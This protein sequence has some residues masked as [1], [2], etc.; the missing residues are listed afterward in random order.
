MLVRRTRTGGRRTRLA[1]LSAALA[2]TLLAGPAAAQQPAADA[3]LD[4]LIR[5]AM[6]YAYPYNEFMTMRQAALHDQD[7]PTATTLNHFRHARQLATP[8][9]RWANGPINDALYST[10]W[11]DVGRSPIVLSLPDTAGR[12]YVIALVGANLDTFAYVGRRI[13]GTAARRVAIVGPE[14][15]GTVP[16]VEQVIRAPTRD[17]YLNMRVLVDGPGDLPTAQALQ[18][19]FRTVPA[20]A[21]AGADEPG[22]VP[23]RGDWSRFVAVANESL[24]RNPPPPREAPLLARFR[25]VGICGSACSWTALPADVQAR[26]QRLAPEIEQT[27]KSRLDADRSTPDPRRQN[28]WVPY[29]LPASFGTNYLMRAAS[30]AMSGGILGVEAAEASYF[31]ASVD[32]QNA[33]LGQGAAYRLHLPQGRLPADAF[34]SISL[35]EFVP[36]GQYLVENPINRYAIGDRTRGLQFNSDGSLDIWIQPGDP[37]PAR[38]ANW[39]PSPAHNRFYLMARLYQP[40]P[41]ALDP[42][43]VLAPLEK[44]DH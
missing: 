20:D 13:S 7:G 16:G 33:A 18:D 42:S 22:V 14:W 32:G 24:A 26:W 5:E 8:K 30:A 35:Y 1:V 23:A 44:L 4:T 36:G 2:A 10:N 19:A 12:Y 11:L 39:L 37:G 6:L 29:R 34:W 28:G 15:R 31:A 25:Q 21:T 17:V 40:W 38:R 9:D 43:W 27:L 3:G 41:L